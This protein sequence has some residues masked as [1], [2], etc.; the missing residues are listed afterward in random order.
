MN[1]V[2]LFGNKQVPNPAPGMKAF[3]PYAAGNKT[4]GGGRPMPNIG[5]VAHPQGYNER[6]NRAQAKKN[7]ILRRMKG[8]NTGNP[9]NSNVMGYGSKGVFS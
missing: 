9:M 8:A 3:N 5:P 1:I 4:Y 7:A 2:D 6:D